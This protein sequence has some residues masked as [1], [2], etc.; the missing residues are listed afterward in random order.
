MDDFF[1]FTRAIS[2]DEVN[3]I[4]NGQLIAVEPQDKLTTTWG[5]IKAKQ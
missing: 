4:M 2:A 1:L 3:A 5:I